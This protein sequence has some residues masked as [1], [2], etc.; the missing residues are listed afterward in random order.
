MGGWAGC[1]RSATRFASTNMSLWLILNFLHVCVHPTPDQRVASF[2]TL[3]DMQ[4]GEDLEGAQEPPLCVDPGSGK[5]FMDTTGY[6]SPWGAPHTPSLLLSPGPLSSRFSK[7]TGHQEII[8]SCTPQGLQDPDTGLHGAAPA[9]HPAGVGGTWQQ[10]C[11]AV[12]G[13]CLPRHVTP[14]P[15]QQGCLTEGGKEGAWL[16]VCR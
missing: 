1:L 14:C 12:G 3:T 6:V 11:S 5:E 8:S 13:P 16:C 15:W 10:K 9:S 7:A 4:H 2:C